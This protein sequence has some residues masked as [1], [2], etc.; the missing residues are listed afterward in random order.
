[1]LVRYS[2]KLPEIADQIDSSVHYSLMKGYRTMDI[3]D[4]QNYIKTSEMGD[5]I[6]EFLINGKNIISK[7]I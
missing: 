4:G 2:M 7:N 3:S 1:M 6:T 5:I